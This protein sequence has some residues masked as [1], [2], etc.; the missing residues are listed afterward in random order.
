ETIASTTK[1]QVDFSG[2]IKTKEAAKQAFDFGAAQIAIGSLAVKNPKEFV[3]WIWTFSEEKLI[4]GADVIN[5][6]V[7]VSG[8]QETSTKDI[9]SF[10]D[11]YF[12]E[13]ID[14]VLCT[15]VSKDGMLQGPS[16]DLYNTILEEYEE[17]KLIASGGVSSVEDLLKLKEM[18]CYAAIVGKAFY[19][20][21]ITIAQLKSF[22]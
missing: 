21:K 6:K 10:L 18:G 4:L 11:F 7:A 1:L 14:Y 9:Y 3:D 16:F 15:D 2:G 19:E 22:I 17:I 8:W 13:G 12:E 20:G 5:G